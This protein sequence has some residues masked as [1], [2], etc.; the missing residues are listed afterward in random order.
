MRAW[1]PKDEGSKVKISVSYNDVMIVEWTQKLFEGGF[2]AWG[3]SVTKQA[4]D[5]FLIEFFEL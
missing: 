4:K 2:W 1:T 5:H 3:T